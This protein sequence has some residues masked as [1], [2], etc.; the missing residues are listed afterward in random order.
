MVGVPGEPV[1]PEDFANPIFESIELDP[2][3]SSASVA[4]IFNHGYSL[5]V[6]NAGA[7]GNNTRVWFE[8]PDQGEFIVGPRS[9]GSN[10]GSIRLRTSATT[11]SA[12]TCHIDTSG[13]IRRSTSARRYK[14]DI[15]DHTLDL[16]ALRS[17]RVVSFLARNEVEVH[18][19]WREEM[20]TAGEPVPEPAVRRYVGVIAEELHDAGLTELV[21]YHD[22]TGEPDGVMYDRIALG[23]LQ[24]I[25]QQAQW[26]A[27]LEERIAALEGRRPPGTPNPNGGS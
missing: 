11:A 26:I 19:R 6:D 16:D 15:R 2:P 24:L 23:A 27:E 12:A 20:E 18:R 13:T 1:D 8:G 17:L 21:A 5:Y 4:A 3:E 22:E 7:G 14:T 25:E 10:F 9:G